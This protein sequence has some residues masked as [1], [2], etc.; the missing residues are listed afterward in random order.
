MQAAEHDCRIN[1]KVTTYRVRDT[2]DIDRSQS[3]ASVGRRAQCCRQ[4]QD[5]TD[6][7]LEDTESELEAARQACNR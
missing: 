1:L 6:Q 5:Q 4:K 3:R 2:N 7:D